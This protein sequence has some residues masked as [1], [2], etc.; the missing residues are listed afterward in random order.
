MFAIR[1][2]RSALRLAAGVLAFAALLAILLAVAFPCA[3]QTAAPV[4]ILAAA[5]PGASSR[6]CDW[7]DWSAFKRSTISADGRV[8][9]ASTP[10]LITTSEGQSYALFFSLVANDRATFSKVLT[11]TENNLAKGDL[12][13]QLPAWLW[14]R[15]IP[16]DAASASTPAS[17]AQTTQTWTVL[18][19]NPAS[20]SDLWIAWT[21]L[22]AGRLWQRRHY[23][24]LGTLMARNI[25]REETALLPGLGRTLLPGPAGFAP[26][27]GLWRLNPSYVPLQ[28]M[29]GMAYALPDQPEWRALLDT[30]ARLVNETAPHGFSPDWV[31][32]RTSLGFAPDAKTSAQGS[33]DAIRV[34]LW[35]GML[36]AADPL[37]TATLRTFAPLANH[38]A[39]HG[40][41][42]ERVDTQTG[43]L[44]PNA[45]NGG[46]SAAVAPYLAALGR[47]DLAA[48]QVARSRSMAKAAP[49]GY[50]T[51]VLML[52]GLGYLDG[53]YR[54][55]PNGQLVPAW[56]STCATPH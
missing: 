50:Y 4:T 44:G 43:A 33:Y 34:Y 5:A 53:L 51:E 13:T 19:P 35:A 6:T 25:V 16:A 56:K 22:E 38:V 28:L 40:Y 47:S 12:T 23:T 54:F 41:P 37:R 2:W 27:P 9:D 1:P 46:F 45:G 48:A 15:Q 55:D 39:V 8:I 42:P 36:D 11:W 52:F 24:A 32:F 30:S 29:R 49:S 20:D 26:A 18:D 3:A 21:L 31:E 14:G 17:G 10:K 7:P